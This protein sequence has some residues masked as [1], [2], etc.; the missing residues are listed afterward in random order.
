MFGIHL[1]VGIPLH[2][3]KKKVGNSISELLGFLFQN[4]FDFN[5]CHTAQSNYVHLCKLLVVTDLDDFF[6]SLP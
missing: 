6:F 4:S 5:L 2:F 3:F 1:K